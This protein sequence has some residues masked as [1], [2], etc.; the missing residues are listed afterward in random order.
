MT[1]FTHPE[2][3]MLYCLPLPKKFQYEDFRVFGCQIHIHIDENLT[4]NPHQD[5]WVSHK[6]LWCYTSIHLSKCPQR[7]GLYQVPG[8]G[9]ADLDRESGCLKT[10][11][12][13][14]RLCVT[15][16]KPE[17]PVF[18]DHITYSPDYHVWGV[19]KLA[20]NTTLCNTKDELMA[21]ITVAFSILNK[22]TTVKACRRLS[23]GHDWIQR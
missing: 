15:P 23:E 1:Q 13:A 9:S 12:L 10:L 2:N 20:T 14:T 17:N 6:E 7:G 11:C 21:R 19:V 22:K 4:P 5:V 8:R 18:Y 3:G 16:N